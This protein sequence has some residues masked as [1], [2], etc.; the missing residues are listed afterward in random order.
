MAGERGREGRQGRSTGGRGRGRGGRGR[1][2]GRRGSS[3]RGRGRGRG[4]DS[5]SGSGSGSGRGR[6]RGRGGGENQGGR[7]A[8]AAGTARPRDAEE[9]PRRSSRRR[10]ESATT[11][12]NP[13]PHPPTSIRDTARERPR[14]STG[15]QH[16]QDSQHSI[17]H[18]NYRG[19]R[20][21]AQ[22]D[23]PQREPLT[24]GGI[25]LDGQ[26][27]NPRI[28]ICDQQLFPITCDDCDIG[29]NTACHHH[30]VVSCNKVDC[31]KRFHKVCLCTGLSTDATLDDL[32]DSYTCMECQCRDES[33]GE[34]TPYAN[35]PLRSNNIESLNERLLRFGL[36]ALPND[37]PSAQRSAART[38]MKHLK[39][40]LDKCNRDLT[41]TP[42]ELQASGIDP[43]GI[44]DSKPRNYPS[45][46]HMAPES[47]DRHVRTGR[48]AEFSL[49]LYGVNRC[50]C[51]G[52]VKPNHE[53]PQFPKDAPF[54]RMHLLNKS[55]HAWHCT[56]LG[57]C[58]GSQFYASKRSSVMSWY[59]E[60]HG[61]QSPS[62]Y[63][64]NNHGTV[65]EVSLCQKCYDE[66]KPDNL[67][68]REML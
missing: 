30:K 14:P 38:K 62:E 65:A 21:T 20:N 35:F 67:S 53:D 57:Y 9:T 34:D 45:P 60:K 37:A 3:G 58:K 7:A 27:L 32:A 28:C 40:A 2:R 19:R 18:V 39:T 48:R 66:V 61:G 16:S 33:A 5:G 31:E 1:G 11:P 47:I 41:P 42:P 15:S 44:L 54:Q 55:H 46:V 56:C 49:S 50:S 13:H 63:E 12:T 8:A 24:G 22:S 25:N 17:Y 36:E 52:S 68:G 26:R 43:G 10:L 23:A 64:L 6:G 29:S 51:C 59:K 4:R